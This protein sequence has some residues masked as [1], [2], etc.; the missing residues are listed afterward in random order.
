MMKT[1]NGLPTREDAAKAPWPLFRFSEERPYIVAE[2]AR[3]VYKEYLT[4]ARRSESSGL[5]Y[6]L[7]EAAFKEATRLATETGPEEE[8][9]DRG[10]WVDISKRLTEM[11]E[12][13][14]RDI[15]RGLVEE[16]SEDIAGQFDPSV[17]RLATQALPFGL[18]VLFKAQDLK[19]VTQSVPNILPALRQLRDLSERVVVEGDVDTLRQLA[20]KGTLLFVPTHS[21]NMDSILVG[22]SLFASGLPPV[23]YGAGKNLF[24]NPLTSF[25][26][27]NLGAY[28]VDRRLNHDLYKQTLKMYSQ[29]ALE[30]GYHSLFFPGGTRCRSNIVEQHLKLG[31]LGT[32]VSAYTHNLTQRRKDERI[33]VCPL[34]INYNLVLEA[35]SLIRDHLRREG[36]ARY[37]LEDDPFDQ[38]PAIVRFAMNTMSMES[39]TILRFGQPMDPFGNRVERDGHSYDARGRRVDPTSYVR[40]ARTGEVGFD[41]MRDREYTRYTGGRIAEAFK[42]NTVIMPVTV[43]AYVLFELLRQRFPSWDV[44]R[45]LR[46]GGEEVISWEDLRAGVAELMRELNTKHQRGELHLAPLLTAERAPRIA[47]AGVANLRMYHQPEVVD[48]HPDGIL[49]DR[50]DLLYFYSNRLREYGIDDRVWIARSRRM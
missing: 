13:E 38:L 8:I 25:F 7:N 14:K 44:Y 30:R 45:I 4:E 10:W 32:A 21:S 1:P 40:S 43:V 49:L 37:F 50:L 36:G 6:V 3:R 2:V 9:K 29:A 24:A 41:E 47:E 16:Y 19:G 23:T 17:Y 5:E 34:T 26:M 18:G 39:T 12:Q 35:E 20:R 46:M 48:F 42:Q 15:L 28:K 11:S 31:L 22:Y 27:H 33:Y